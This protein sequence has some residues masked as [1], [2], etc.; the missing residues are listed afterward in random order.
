V[1]KVAGELLCDYYARHFKV[2]VRSIRYPGIISYS[3]PPGGGTTDYA[4]EIFHAALQH[5]TYTCFVEPDTRLPM[6]YMP[7][8]VAA[9]LRLMEAP[10]D[11]IRIRSAYNLDALSF[12][13]AELVDEIRTYR[14]DFVCRY[15]PDFRQ[16]IAD[17]WPS[18]VDDRHARSD[19][20]WRPMFDLPRLV[21][22]MVHHLA[23]RL[24]HRGINI[25]TIDPTA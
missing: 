10:P 23:P 3:A 9:A 5:G 8:A 21:A 22:D 19:W 24:S 1:T 12:S 6:M 7:D 14:P 25:P 13:V 4:V 2:D 20:G 17:S 15:E 16:E 11:A 18:T